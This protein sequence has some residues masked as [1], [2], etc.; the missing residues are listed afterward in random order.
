MARFLTDFSNLAE[1]VALDLETTGLKPEFDRI[2]SICLI[3]FDASHPLEE[4][5]TIESSIN[6]FAETI[7]PTIQIPASASKIHGITNEKV[8]GCRN[9]SEIVSE[10]KQ[11][12]GDAPLISHNME[13]DGAFLDFEMARAGERGF[14][15]NE[16]FCTMLAVH[17]RACLMAKKNV[18]WPKLAESGRFA[19]VKIDQ[20]RTH[21]AKEDAFNVIRLV[22][23]LRTTYVD[24]K[25]RNILK[26]NNLVKDVPSR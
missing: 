2:V 7:N 3:R 13:F 21:N 5:G 24:T 16:R 23:G 12:I 22:N 11:I 10:I 6:I 9:F 8:H 19:G 17:R 15:R 14:R 26:T 4:S 25:T 18:K 1:A 20:S